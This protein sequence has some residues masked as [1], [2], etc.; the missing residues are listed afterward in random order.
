MPHICTYATARFEY[1][2]RGRM[3]WLPARRCSTEGVA[4]YEG[5]ALSLA[6]W[7]LTPQLL[8]LT[9]A[10][11]RGGQYDTVHP[12]L[13]ARWGL[14]PHLVHSNGAEPCSPVAGLL[15]TSCGAPL[16]AVAGGAVTTFTAAGAE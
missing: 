10:A 3:D 9:S 6:T 11:C 12:Y 15:A 14:R 7:M 13:A 1:V 8:I 4:S 2:A 16:P 5:W